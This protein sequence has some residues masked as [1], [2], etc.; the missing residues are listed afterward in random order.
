LFARRVLLLRMRQQKQRSESTVCERQSSSHSSA[1]KLLL[2]QELAC[3][4]ARSGQR[5]RRI[6]LDPARGDIDSDARRLRGHRSATHVIFPKPLRM[7]CP[8]LG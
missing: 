7:P 8:D 3:A 1:E 4:V 5:A 2:Y 6:L